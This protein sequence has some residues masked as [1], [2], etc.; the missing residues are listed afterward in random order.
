M[1]KELN[2]LDMV[3]KYRDEVIDLL[4]DTIMILYGSTVF[5]INTSDLDVCF[6]KEKELTKEEFEK[7][8]KI[9]RDFHNKNNLK[10]DEEVPYKN[11]LVYTKSF[12][13]DTLINLP[14]PFVDGKY[15]IPKIIKTPEFLSSKE[16]S[17][18]LLLNILTVKNEILSGNNKIIEKYSEKAW[19]Q[20][21]KVVISYSQ[22]NNFTIEEVIM[23][24]HRDPFSGVEGEFY[25][26]YKINMKEKEIY[27]KNKIQENL[28]KLES[29][30]KIVKTLKKKY[31]PNKGWLKN[32]KNKLY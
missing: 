20:I 9:T 2:S 28:C 12:I 14:F 15:I 21:L 32:E 11:K 25:L 19:E 10:I 18:R 3:K 16:M 26:G 30:N 29:E 1:M 22:I 31:I 17:Q 7:L 27:I 23:N 24:L 5:G 8:E 13:E 4:D 6:I